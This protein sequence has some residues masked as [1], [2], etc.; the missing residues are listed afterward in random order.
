MYSYAILMH[1]G[2]NHVYFQ[3]ALDFAAHEFAVVAKHFSAQEKNINTKPIMQNILVFIYYM[4]F[5]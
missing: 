5:N 3:S 2:H 1:P 4:F